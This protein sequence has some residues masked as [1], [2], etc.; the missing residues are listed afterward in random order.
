MS[1][2]D[3]VFHDWIQ[4]LNILSYK[5]CFI[6]HD[7]SLLQ[8][9]CCCEGKY[10][11]RFQRKSEEGGKKGFQERGTR[12]TFTGKETNSFRR[13]GGDPLNLTRTRLREGLLS[14]SSSSLFFFLFCWSSVVLALLLLL[15]LLLNFFIPPSSPLFMGYH[16]PSLSQDPG[17]SSAL[18]LEGTRRRRR[19]LQSRRRLQCQ[20]L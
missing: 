17:K 13:A 9:L 2:P 8:T 20:S 19:S 15:P 12:R 11:F 4:T 3:S 6:F 7:S 16:L 18:L 1:C 5:C 10:C 14:P